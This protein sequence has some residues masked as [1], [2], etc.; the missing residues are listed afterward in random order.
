MAVFLGQQLGLVRL[1][2]LLVLLQEILDLGMIILISSLHLPRMV[3]LPLLLMPLL[4]L[5]HGLQPLNLFLQFLML[6]LIDIL[7]LNHL[8]RGLQNLGL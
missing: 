5:E 1:L 8:S 4:L 3:V 2:G 6:T 7:V